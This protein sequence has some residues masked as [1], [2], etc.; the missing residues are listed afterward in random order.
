MFDLLIKG[1]R[2]PESGLSVDIGISNGLIAEIGPS[3]TTPAQRVIDA[4]GRLV[5]P[6]FVDP[7]FHMDATLSLGLPRLNR[8]GT[9]L[10]GIALWGELKPLLTV[11]AVME[12][13]LRYCDLAVSQGLAGDP[14]PCRCL[15]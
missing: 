9:L 11:E 6:P 1:G 7:H 13:A 12:R 10:E 4:T 3:L 5:A 15:R 8:S 14:H 2:L